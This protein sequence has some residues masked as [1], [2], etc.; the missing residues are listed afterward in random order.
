MNAWCW[1]SSA[2]VCALLFLLSAYVFNG[3]VAPSL[4]LRAACTPLRPAPWPACPCTSHQ[5]FSLAIAP[6]TNH[7]RRRTPPIML[8]VPLQL[9]VTRTGRKVS[10]MSRTGVGSTRRFLALGCL[11]LVSGFRLPEDGAVAQIDADGNPLSPHESTIT[12]E[13]DG[14]HDVR[15]LTTPARAKQQYSR[16]GGAGWCVDRFG[17]AE[18]ARSY[19]PNAYSLDAMQQRCSSDHN[20]V[21]VSWRPGF[22]ALHTT[23]DC[24]DDCADDAVVKNR[25]LIVGAGGGADASAFR[26][27]V[28]VWVAKKGLG[29]SCDDDWYVPLGPRPCALDSLHNPSFCLLFFAATRIMGTVGEIRSVHTFSTH[30]RLDATTAAPTSTMMT[31]PLPPVHVMKRPDVMKRP[32][33]TLHHMAATIHSTAATCVRPALTYI[34]VP[35]ITW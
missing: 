33:N 12:G 17:S 6:Q 15:R 24:V 16:V 20:C 3:K 14:A 22:A 13:V 8:Q 11:A 4:L 28:K 23:T 30:S 7:K 29:S 31:A 25:K 1:T 21:A 34:S 18:N 32:R 5:D 2:L 35:V 10:K 27:W 19:F 26:C 9:Q